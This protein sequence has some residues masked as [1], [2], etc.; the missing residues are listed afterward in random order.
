MKIVVAIDSFKGCLSS[1]EAGDAATAG[2]KLTC[3]DCEVVRIPVADGG[4]GMMDILVKATHGTYRTIE[5]HDP[6]MGLIPA[7]YGISGD[8]KTAIIEM[9]AASGLPL[10][11]EQLRNPMLTTTFGTGELIRDALEYGCRKFIIGIGGSATNDAGLG[12]LQALGFRFTDKEGNVLGQGGRIMQEVATIDAS[13]SHPAL[14]KATFTVACDVHNPF[15]GT[16][17][18]APV[19]A[20][21]KGA[22][23]K[24]IRELDNGMRLLA[25]RIRRYSGRDI[26]N[27]PGAGAAGG[28]GG[29]FVAF[30]NAALVPGADLLINACNFDRKISDANLVITGEGKMDRQTAMG[31]IPYAILKT[32]QSRQIPVIAIAGSVEDAEELN[33]AGFKGVFSITT[34]P[35]TLEKAMEPEVA[36]TN[37]KR[38]VAQ[39][40]SVIVSFG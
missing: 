35:T 26:T 22:D 30:L 32:A 28:M 14:K 38:L 18:A 6:L 12:M 31:K 15:C 39:I 19:F 36:K 24:M 8:R 27:I 37:I 33:A 25:D 16:N 1:Q 34:G 5:A 20:R 13:R 7:T 21:Q 9:A 4:E 23:E 10:V 3:P 29:G 11:R 40:C 2:I 17:G